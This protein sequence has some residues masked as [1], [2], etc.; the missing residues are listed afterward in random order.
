MSF[1]TYLLEKKIDPEKFKMDDEE[2]YHA[3]Q[4]LF[5][6]MHPNSFTAQKLYLINKIRRKYHLKEHG[7]QVESL[8]QAKKV[9][10]RIVP[11]I[12]K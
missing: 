8:G 6:Q 12:K 2:S 10:P 11:K 9:K 5:S 3:M 1:Q 4:A 7:Q